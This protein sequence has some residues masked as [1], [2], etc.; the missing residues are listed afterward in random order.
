[1]KLSTMM[2]KT[3]IALLIIFLLTLPVLSQKRQQDTVL[4]REVTLYNPYKPSL[5]DVV[6]KSFLP[7]MNDS[8][9]V[10]PVFKYDLR[11][12]PFMPSYTA[13]LIKPASLMPDPLPKLYN[14]YIVIGLGN[15]LTPLAEISITNGRSK[16]G[17]IG[18]D[19]RH[20]STNGKV[21]LQNDKKAFAG[22]MDNDA[23]IFGKRYLKNSILN[24]SVDLSQ[25][26]R[27]AYGYDTIFKNWDPAKKDIRLNYLNT[28]ARIGMAST[29]LDSSSLSYNFGLAYN[30]F[31]DTRKLYQHNVDFTGLMAKSYKGFYAGSGFE[32]DYF[33]YSDSIYSNPRYIAS[34]SPFIKKRSD[35]WAVKLGFQALLDKSVTESA[36]FHIYPDL[37]FSFNVVP[38]Y[39]GFFIDMSG[40]LVKNEPINV[41]GENPFIFPD[42]TLFRI[43]NTDYALIVKAGLKGSDGIEGY[44]QLS[45]SYSVVNDLL[46]YSN[47]VI[48]GDPL[49]SHRG[50]F[51]IPITDD[52]N[53]MNVHGELSGKIVDLLSFNA[54]GN[55]YRYTLTSNDY[56]WNKPDWDA[57]IGLKYNLMN[58]IIAGANLNALGKRKALVTTEDLNWNYP[59]SPTV[60]IPATLSFNLNA[61]YRYTKTLSFWI[62]LNNI[63]FSRYYEWAFYPAQRFMCLVGFT[64]SL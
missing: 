53:I 6:K 17:A 36:K 58:K 10:K 23:S 52:G 25:K 40:K 8:A 26:T 20:F 39:V 60:D 14:S 38:S 37:N 5:Q 31:Y 54:E 49:T 62:K 4:R 33:S 12:E 45:A 34:I 46:L 9:K 59:I 19:V 35:E 18:L 32:F 21:E 1:M 15:Y 57:S 63:S 2:K 64:Y 43:P 27:Y 3:I 56:A 30:F 16:N 48:T 55:W 24:G 7:D 29:K 13:N 42:L 22:Y 28:G 11:S 47:Y 61:E 51:F 41:I 44:Y 50:N